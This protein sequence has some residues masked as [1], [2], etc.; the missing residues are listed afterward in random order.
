MVI[1]SKLRRLLHLELTD[2][3]SKNF[4]LFTLCHLFVIAC[5]TWLTLTSRY[6]ITQIFSIPY[7]YFMNALCFITCY[8]CYSLLFAWCL[9]HNHFYLFCTTYVLLPTILIIIMYTKPNITAIAVDGKNYWGWIMVGTLTSC[10]GFLSA[11]S[12]WVV[13]NITEHNT[14]A[15]HFLRVLEL[16]SAAILISLVI[17]GTISA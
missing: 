5:F 2:E 1:L 14:K 6:T 3:Q 8:A 9:E 7:V 4:W 10:W 17:L 13:T 16:L 11:L 15:L 12:I